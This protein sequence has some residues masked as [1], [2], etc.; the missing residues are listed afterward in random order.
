MS[1]NQKYLEFDNIS[2]DLRHV[3]FPRAIDEAENLEYIV[4]LNVKRAMYC[5]FK[6]TTDMSLETLAMH[7]YE[8]VILCK[9]NVCI[10]TISNF[11]E[12]DFNKFVY[13]KT[14]LNKSI[15]IELDD[16]A[17]VIVAECIQ[18]H[19]KYHQRITGYMDFEK[20]HKPLHDVHGGA[21]CSNTISQEDRNKLDRQYETIL[22]KFA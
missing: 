7:I 19:E 5:N 4:F 1:I 8:D 3:H 16:E 12:I 21:Y 11:N 15:I 9:D 13:N 18:P 17:R 6:I 20:R 22:Y 14:D 2:V 10:R